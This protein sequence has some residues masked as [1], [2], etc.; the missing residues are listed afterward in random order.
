MSQDS[1]TDIKLCDFGFAKHLTLGNQSASDV[2]GTLAYLAP[3]ILEGLPYG[4]KV[5]YAPLLVW[6]S[7]NVQTAEASRLLAKLYCELML[8]RCLVCTIFLFAYL[9]IFLGGGGGRCSLRHRRT[10]RCSNEGI[11]LE[12]RLRNRLAAVGGE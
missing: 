2:A 5:G 3:E 1:D 10:Q 7:A 8:D 9:F 4:N 6:N 11:I 12:T